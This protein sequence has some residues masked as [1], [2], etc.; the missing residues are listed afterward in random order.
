[1]RLYLA[2]AMAMVLLLAVGCQAASIAPAW[3]L[4]IDGQIDPTMAG[5]ISQGIKEAQ[6]AAAQ[7]VLV[8]MNTH[9]GLMSSME[10]IIKAFYS[11]TIPIIVYV[12]PENARAASAGGYITMAADIAAMAPSSRIGSL[13]PISVGASGEE[14]KISNTMQRKILNDAV[15]EAR[16]IANKRGRNADWA[17][18]GV[19]EAANVTAEEAVKLNVV[20]L[21]ATS[22]RDLLTKIDGKEIKVSTGETVVLRTAK[23]PL[24]DRPMKGW[25]SFLHYLSNPMVAMLL[26][27]MATYGIIFELSNPGAILPGVVGGI[28]AILLLYSFSVIPINAA[29]FAFIALA[30]VLFIADVYA[31][32]HGVLSVGGV[33]SLFFGLMMLF[34]SPQGPMI[35]LWI[36]ALVAL[37]TGGFFVFVVA[38]G[39]RALK[40]PYIAGREGVVGHIGD[41]RTDLD[42][43]GRIFVDGALWTATSV[44]GT[45]NK[46]E[47]VLVVSMDGLKLTVEKH[48]LD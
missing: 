40:K 7:A 43:T 17:E 34:G 38:L 41:A 47:T 26:L 37:L 33:I 8:T 2:L 23:A 25:Q 11:S 1:M 22:T 30:I 29:G 48:E 44:S 13:S 15:S 6:D 42:P 3:V 45:I 10:D 18:K 39:L 24:T 32:S 28:S 9:G 12:T 14:Q 27:L 19:R 16:G 20:D 35:S 36:L 4:H 31:P 21:L 46:G 5:Y